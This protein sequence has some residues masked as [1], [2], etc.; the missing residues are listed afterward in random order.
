MPPSEPQRTIRFSYGSDLIPKK[1]KLFP[2]FV[3][4]FVTNDKINCPKRKT[5]L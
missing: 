1:Q 5:I 2:I 3:S 4:Y